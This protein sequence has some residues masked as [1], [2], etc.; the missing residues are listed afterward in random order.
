MQNHP[1]TR[2]LSQVILSLDFVFSPHSWGELGRVSTH[3]L[4]AL[5]HPSSFSVASQTHW[6]PKWTR[7]I[8]KMLFLRFSPEHF[9][10]TG[11]WWGLVG[12]GGSGWE[13]VEWSLGTFIDLDFWLCIVCSLFCLFVFIP[14]EFSRWLSWATGFGATGCLTQWGSFFTFW[15]WL[16]G[17]ITLTLEMFS[18]RV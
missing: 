7:A 13:R 9:D 15:G 18:L 1:R 3:K 12:A 14:P 17:N 16:E 2:Q 6:S 5:N 10:L 11:S 8:W 4:K